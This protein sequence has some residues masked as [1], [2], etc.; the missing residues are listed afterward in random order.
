[1]PSAIQER[2]IEKGRSERESW[3]CA[4]SRCGY[5]T[6]RLPKFVCFAS[7]QNSLLMCVF[8]CLCLSVRVYVCLCLSCLSLN[9]LF[10]LCTVKKSYT[11]YLP[12]LAI[13]LIRRLEHFPS[14]VNFSAILLYIDSLLIFR[15]YHIS[16]LLPGL[17][18]CA[19]RIKAPVKRENENIKL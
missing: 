1:M 3:N 10:V 11:I 18:V 15:S 17:K 4:V 16:I 7:Q 5:C 6:F 8:V 2:E 19:Y 9:R 12:T 13:L 14:R